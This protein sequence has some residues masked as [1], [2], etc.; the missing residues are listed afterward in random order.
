MGF[1]CACLVRIKGLG[2]KYWGMGDEAEQGSLLIYL[3]EV[4]W[5]PKGRLWQIVEVG[6]ARKHHQLSLWS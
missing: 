4:L 3:A 6:E 5:M 1:L 2:Q